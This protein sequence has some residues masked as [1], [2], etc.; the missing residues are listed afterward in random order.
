MLAGS[1]SFRR[2]QAH[3]L[4]GAHGVEILRDGDPALEEAKAARVRRALKRIE[5]P[6]GLRPLEGWW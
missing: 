1:A 4:L 3:D 6:V 5:R 2:E